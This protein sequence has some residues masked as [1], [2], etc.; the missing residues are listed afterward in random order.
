MIKG[1]LA[2]QVLREVPDQVCSFMERNGLQPVA[3]QQN[4]D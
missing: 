2:E 3:Q 4:L 1:D